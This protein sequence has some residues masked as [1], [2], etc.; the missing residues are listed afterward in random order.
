[1][2]PATRL[3]GPLAVLGAGR[4]AHRRSRPDGPHGGHAQDGEHRP[5]IIPYDYR[6]EGLMVT[7]DSTEAY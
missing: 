1:M 7:L 6:V 5:M 2:I 4:F 3:P